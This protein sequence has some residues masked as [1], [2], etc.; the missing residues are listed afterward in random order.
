MTGHNVEII[1]PT[2][3]RPAHVGQKLYHF[4][5]SNCEFPIRIVD[6]SDAVTSQK[7]EHIC[8]GYA[9][10][11]SLSYT[12]IS[13]E[14]GYIQKIYWAISSSVA[15]YVVVHSDDDFLNVDVIPELTKYLDENHDFVAATGTTLSLRDVP[16][17]GPPIVVV[18]KNGYEDDDEP[19]DRA[20]KVADVY[21]E[22]KICM[23]NVWRRDIFLSVLAPISS[24]PYKK[25]S[26]HML[27]FLAAFAGKTYFLD[28]LYE[29]RV[30]DHNKKMRRR[31]SLPEFGSD[32]VSQLQSNEFREDLNG[33]A[34]TVSGLL[35]IN[36]EK[37]STSTAETMAKQLF[38]YRFIST[39]SLTA[40]SCPG[41][42]AVAK[43]IRRLKKWSVLLNVR[44]MMFSVLMIRQYGWAI[45]SSM[46]QRD[47]K[48]KYCYWTMVRDKGVRGHAFR[49]MMV[50]INSRKTDKSSD[51]SQAKSS[52][53]L[54]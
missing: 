27:G 29:M 3:Q 49:N 11:L 54:S 2:Y 52:G 33:Y 30:I 46:L 22:G 7:N 23:Y 8:A 26:E 4:W 39:K 37:K 19:W 47:P 12:R 44:R 48:F 42:S 28:E 41:E 35:S 21:Y 13:P 50:A 45:T 31:N 38:L 6:T 17:I 20:R 10:R 24:N 1:V 14:Y 9:T 43:L 32:R 18:G 16:E 36:E 53:S 5:I 40:L 51:F 15:E 25:Y 34:E